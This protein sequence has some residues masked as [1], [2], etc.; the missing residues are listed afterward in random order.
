MSLC[1]GDHL[2][3]K[4]NGVLV[5]PKIECYHEF[6]VM[7]SVVNGEVQPYISGQSA[8]NSKHPAKWSHDIRIEVVE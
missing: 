8:S 3:I 2:V 4:R 7:G 5:D 6:E 1:K